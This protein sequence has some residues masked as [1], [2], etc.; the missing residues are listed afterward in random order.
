MVLSQPLVALQVI[1]ATTFCFFLVILHFPPLQ[2][3]VSAFFHCYHFW[4][5]LDGTEVADGWLPTICI[6]TLSVHKL[7][8]SLLL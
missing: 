1:A 6:L 2:M 7:G 8:S 4:V 5:S 3:E